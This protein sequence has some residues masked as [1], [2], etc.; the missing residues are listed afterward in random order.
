MKWIRLT[1]GSQT[2]RLYLRGFSM[3][4][5]CSRFA[6]AKSHGRLLEMRP[7]CLSSCTLINRHSNRRTGP[8]MT[9]LGS[10]DWNIQETPSG[11]KER[12]KTQ[13]MKRQR[14]KC[15]FILTFYLHPLSPFVC[16]LYFDLVVCMHSS[17]VPPTAFQQWD[18]TYGADKNPLLEPATL[19]GPLPATPPLTLSFYKTGQH[20]TWRSFT[21]L[22]D[23]P[24][25][26]GIPGFVGS[27]VFQFIWRRNIYQLLSLLRQ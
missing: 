19:A 14:E 4:W 2:E 3:Q 5:E 21:F 10:T 8:V 15:G 12:E 1:R 16:S 25:F 9:P 20:H 24:R 6:L 22:Y 17:N 7:V 18:V 26:C 13:N 27:H 23:E 11:H